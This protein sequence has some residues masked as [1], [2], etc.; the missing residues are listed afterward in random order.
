MISRFTKYLAVLGLLSLVTAC[1]GGTSSGGSTQVSDLPITIIMPTTGAAS[2]VGI[3]I[4]HAFML[5]V[6]DINAKGGLKIG[7]KSYRFAVTSVDDAS[8][9][10][11]A[12]AAAHSAISSGAKVIFGPDTNLESLPVMQLAKGQDV[13]NIQCCAAQPAVTIYHDPAQY[14]NV[15]S[16]Q[17]T[18]QQ[19]Q[20]CY[21]P[22]MVKQSKA[23]K[24]AVL[25]NQAANPTFLQTI[26]G[27][28][29][30]GGIA[31]PDI[32]IQQFPNG[33]Q[34]FTP[35]LSKVAQGNP[36]MI[37]L[38]TLGLSPSST[39]LRQANDLGLTSKTAFA[40]MQGSNPTDPVVGIG[41]PL[42]GYQW[43]Q[44]G[45]AFD[46][47]NTELENVRS[48]WKKKYGQ[49]PATTNYLTSVIFLGWDGIHMLKNAF[50]KAGAVDVKA[51]A[52][53]WRGVSYKGVNEWTISKD[54]IAVY[55]IQVGRWQAG[56]QVFSECSP[57]LTPIAAG[58]V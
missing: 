55:Q 4:E 12:V 39:P 16:L 10:D 49:D 34:D 38:G 32:N 26:P 45:P 51:L 58:S 14:P 15:V 13:F 46:S 36:D 3:P 18:N 19:L 57:R 40:G 30:K 41:R 33:T 17:P 22:V 35:I 6:E 42:E 37:I 56:K 9:P 53:A 50:E 21:M 24:V 47:G 54:G 7:G 20:D 25:L 52:R 43:P 2:V 29:E 5:G 44:L 31:A 8:N 1:G 48:L 28:L 23:K 27:S 11:Q